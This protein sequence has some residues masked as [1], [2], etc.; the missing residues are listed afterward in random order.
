MSQPGLCD[1]K[2]VPCRGGIPPLTREEALP[3]LAQVPEWKLAA[4]GRSIARAFAFKDFKRALAFV[5]E[6]GAIAEEE[7]HHPDIECG[8]GY[9]R[10]KLWT[11]AIQ[12]LHQNDFILAAKIDA[13]VR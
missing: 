12:G 1:L 7:G 6:V 4:D 2:C 8:W 5:N 13:I 10:F 11:H 9:A 3:L